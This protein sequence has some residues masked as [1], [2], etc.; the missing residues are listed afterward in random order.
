[1]K[2]E[3]VEVAFCREDRLAIGTML[4]CSRHICAVAG[5]AALVGGIIGA[6]IGTAVLGAIT[7][8]VL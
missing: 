6:V 4:V 8:G 1:M 5:A 7:L 2:D 3:T